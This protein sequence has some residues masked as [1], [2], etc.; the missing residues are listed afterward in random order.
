MTS[1]DLNLRQASQII[2][3]F[4]RGRALGM[5]MIAMEIV[6]CILAL[7]SG[8]NWLEL[9]MRLLLLSLYLQWMGVSCAAVLCLARRWLHSSHVQWVFLACWG[10]LVLVVF[11]ISVGARAFLLY[12][13]IDPTMSLVNADFIARN[14]AIGALVSLLLLRY[15]WERHQWL[16]QTRAQSEARYASLQSR[17][18]PHFLFN[19]LNSL[20]ALIRTKPEAAETMVED[21][22]DLFRVSLADHYTLVTLREELGIVEVYLRIERQRLGERLITDIDIPDNLMRLPVPRLTLQPLVENAVFHGI[23]RLAGPGTL[24]IRAWREPGVFFIEVTNP[25]PEAGEPSKSGT[26]VAIGNIRQRLHLLYQEKAS[27]ALDSQE[28]PSQCSFRA[29]LRFPLEERTNVGEL[30]Q[31]RRFS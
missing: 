9:P 4:C 19:A 8:A 24:R 28:G 22:A 17:I 3:E 11:L 26:G 7:A 5:L 18:H 2:P 12:S 1:P 30:F 29:R 10:L 6:A 27:I 15:F 23:A 25:L 21:L 13:H 16:E 14:V 20:A 31:Q